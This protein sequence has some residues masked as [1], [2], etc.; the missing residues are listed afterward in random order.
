MSNLS[1]IFYIKFK[2]IEKFLYKVPS[3]RKLSIFYFKLQK[4]FSRKFKVIKISF[5]FCRKFKVIESFVQKN[6]SYRNFSADMSN[7]SKIS[8]T[9]FKV[10]ENFIYIEFKVNDNSKLLKIF[11]RKFQ[12]PENFLQKYKSYRYFFPLIKGHILMKI[13]TIE[14]IL[15]KIQSYRKSCIKIISY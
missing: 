4:I 15:D 14:S 10:I 7:L 3:Y 11:Q 5:F 6:L 2:V 13:N 8:Y 12:V 1:N 9:K